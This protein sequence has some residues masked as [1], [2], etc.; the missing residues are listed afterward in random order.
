MAMALPLSSQR[1]Y[2]HDHNDLYRLRPARNDLGT[3][4]KLI[5]NEKECQQTIHLSEKGSPN[6]SLT[7]HI[8]HYLWAKS[9][10]TVDNR[11]KY[12]E[13]MAGII[14]LRSLKTLDE[15]KKLVMKDLA[16]QQQLLDVVSVPLQRRIME[17]S[18]KQKLSDR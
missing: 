13:V 4:C 11:N 12:L 5:V 3:S 1:S 18:K 6:V 15:V 7:T 8:S 2:N 14:A 10:T 16:V 9:T 17:R